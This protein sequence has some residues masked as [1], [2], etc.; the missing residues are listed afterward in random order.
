MEIIVKLELAD[1]DL[2]PLA[3]ALGCD[4]DQIEAALAGHATAALHEY[5]EA[6]VGRR[7]FSR[8]SD[9]LEHRLALLT[10]HAFGNRLPGEATVAR[11]FQAT[12]SQARTL[13]RAVVSKYR[14][15]LRDAAVST[16]KDVLEAAVWRESAKEWTVA[17]TSNAV[18]DL[19]NQTL[20]ARHGGEKPISADRTS[21]GVYMVSPA[22]YTKLCGT[23]G[24]VEKAKPAR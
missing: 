14:W 12:P 8:G 9:I 19:L 7:A 10:A 24:A 23:F 16:A 11:L 17:I 6:Y 5:I 18:A 1:A 13:T 21:V 2:E 3:T 15:Q 22:S 4:E 20:A